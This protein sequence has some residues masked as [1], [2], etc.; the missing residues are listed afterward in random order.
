MYS[1]STTGWLSTCDG[2]RSIVGDMSNWYRINELEKLSGVPRRN[3]HFY[4]EQGLLPPPQR[5]GQTMAYYNATHVA[6]LKYIRAAR[7]RRTPLF[8][9]KAQLAERFGRPPAPATARHAHPHAT[10]PPTRRGRPPGRQDMRAR[11]LD[12]GC[13]LFLSR[14]FRDTAVSDITARLNVGKGTF[15]FYFSDKDQLFLECAPRMFQELFAP[16]WDKIRRE[17]NP[18]RRL[19]LRA[20]AVLPVLH[21]FCAILALSR[22]ALQSSRPKIRAMGQQTLASICR[23]LEEDL[24]TAMAHGLVRALDPKATSVMLTGVMESLQY[25]QATGLKFTPREMRNAVSTLILSGIRSG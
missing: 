13:R 3:V 5:T 11:I 1:R 19:E 4:L 17:R 12:V 24:S 15:Y 22:E 9:I 7:A 20:E 10:R 18:L 21:Q 2:W 14:G 6:A 23:P 8:A 16:S 25:L